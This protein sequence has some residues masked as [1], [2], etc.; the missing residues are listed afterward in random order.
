MLLALAVVLV[1]AV[2]VMWQLYRVESR[3]F[4]VEPDALLVGALVRSPSWATCRQRD[5]WPL[6][7]LSGAGELGGPAPFA[8]HARF[9]ESGV[10]RGSLYLEKIEDG[11]PVVR[12]SA[13]SRTVRRD[14]AS[15]RVGS[16]C[17]EPV[18]HVGSG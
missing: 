1:T 14:G 2:V 9:R 18:A 3:R 17:A 6:A 10:R 12:H 8:S 11:R 5:E 15:S 16:E 7:R 13:A 4:F